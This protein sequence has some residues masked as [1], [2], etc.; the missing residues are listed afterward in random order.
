MM[1][2]DV[3]KSTKP[4]ILMRLINWFSGQQPPPLTDT[5]PIKP[6]S[7]GDADQ[8]IIGK[9]FNITFPNG[10]T[11]RAARVKPS[12]PPVHALSALQL[13]K[14]NGML[15]VHGGAGNMEKEHME[16]A[17]TFIT[18]SV[19]PFVQRN[20][21]AVVGGGTQVGTPQILGEAREAIGGTYP[22]IGVVPYGT[23]TYPGGPPP[24]ENKASLNWRHT[25]F[26][27]VEGDE[28]GVE[29][30][31]LVGL[32][33]ASGMPGIALIINGGEIVF[34]EVKKHSASGNQIIAV[35]GTGRKADELADPTSAVR[36]Q[37]TDL[38]K[39]HTVRTDSPDE[40]ASLLTQL[41]PPLNTDTR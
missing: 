29:S 41:I 32:L 9:P 31:L 17:R 10:N 27:F 8:D 37:L 6:P 30:N 22:L 16:K 14:I 18:K 3:A 4:N 19:A 13:P 33:Q 12:I 39:L 26:L 21:L 24:A 28:F 36:R 35:Q 15:I 1:P 20:N 11:A 23:I 40:C 34:N 2:N 38:S 5:A 7:N 25:H